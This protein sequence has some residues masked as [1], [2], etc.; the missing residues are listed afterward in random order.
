MANIDQQRFY[1][2]LESKKFKPVYFLYGDEPYL[3]N[4]CVAR[5]KY[6]VLDESTMDFNYSL[7]YA[8]EADITQVKDTVE[9]LPVFTAQ[10]LVI[11]KGIQ[12]LKDSALQE[13]EPLACRHLE[14]GRRPAALVV[15]GAD[16]E[17]ARCARPDPLV[18]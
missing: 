11:L 18:P 1:K 15:H 13:L 2:D 6:A 16:I 4:Q 9:T 8:G 3:L 14:T 12:D 10:R 17:H 5:F 7:F